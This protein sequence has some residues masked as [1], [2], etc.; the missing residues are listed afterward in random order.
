MEIRFL[1]PDDAGEWLRLR[2]EALEGD[3]EAFS[4]SLEEYRSLSIDEVKKRL[5]P[6]KDAFVVG[7]FEGGSMVGMAGFFREKGPKSRHKGRIWGVY[8]S[9]TARSAGVGRRMMRALLDRVMAIDGVEQV[10]LSVSTT[11]LSAIRLY[12]SLGFESFGREP[13][14]LRIGDRYVDE[15]YM[16]LPVNVPTSG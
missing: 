12:R 8:V 1:T 16:I 5:W 2:V 15:E 10:L 7:A 13:R 14:A 3:P 11:Q 9:P 6:D 4:A